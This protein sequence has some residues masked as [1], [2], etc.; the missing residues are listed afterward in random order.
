MV[1]IL[2]TRAARSRLG[3]VDKVH[4]YSLSFVLPPASRRRGFRQR[5]SAEGAARAAA[6]ARGEAFFT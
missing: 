2:P 3:V 6:E 5:I 4:H 1:S